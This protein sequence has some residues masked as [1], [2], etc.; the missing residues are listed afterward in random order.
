M[1]S[2]P[3]PAESMRVPPAP[4]A[5]AQLPPGSRGRR[6]LTSASR[7]RHMAPV[8]AAV[9]LLH[10]ISRDELLVKDKGLQKIRGRAFTSFWNYG[11]LNNVP[12]VS[13]DNMF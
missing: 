5:V 1:H 7:G 3:P 11:R 10:T 2:L 8:E 4:G 13:K 12:H 9:S 6:R